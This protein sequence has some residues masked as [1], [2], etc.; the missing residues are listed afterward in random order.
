VYN[1]CRLLVPKFL[2]ELV[3]DG[4]MCDETLARVW[5]YSGRATFIT[6]L[7]AEG[8]T[9]SITLKAARHKPASIKTHLRY[10][11][12]TLEDMRQALSKRP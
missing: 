4:A 1:Q 8:H 7:M 3:Q 11:Q 12:L 2:K 5:G 6:Q 10:G 9:T